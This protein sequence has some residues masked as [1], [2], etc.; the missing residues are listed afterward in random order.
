MISESERENLILCYFSMLKELY[1]WNFNTYDV[2]IHDGTSNEGV[3]EMHNKILETIVL[4]DDSNIPSIINELLAKNFL[5]NQSG[6]YS[7]TGK[8]HWND[9]IEIPEELK[10][11]YKQFSAKLIYLLDLGIS[12]MLKFNISLIL[13]N[14]ISCGV[15][16]ENLKR[17]YPKEVNKLL[18]LG[19]T[20]GEKIVGFHES[21]F[22]Y[23]KFN[24][25]LKSEVVKSLV[26]NE[27][28]TL[29]SKCKDFEKVVISV[30]AREKVI[31]RKGIDY[32]SVQERTLNKWEEKLSE[33]VV[34]IDDKVSE[35]SKNTK[36]KPTQITQIIQHLKLKGCL[37]EYKNYTYNVVHE[38]VLGVIPYPPDNF[39]IG[40]VKD[41]E[42]DSIPKADLEEKFDDIESQ[43][44]Q[45]KRKELGLDFIM[46]IK[47]YINDFCITTKFSEH[48]TP[49]KVETLLS[50]LEKDLAKFGWSETEEILKIFEN[51][52]ELIIE[53]EKT[54]NSKWRKLGKFFIEGLRSLPFIP[55]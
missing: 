24:E 9:I 51:E 22:L 4:K 52:F 49:K 31:I 42:I 37:W 39:I 33:I 40:K 13:L 34:N 10:E 48:P 17:L 6:R 27:K 1:D 36:L 54:N 35:C 46:T 50:L 44:R 41:F 43:Q 26:K 45:E 28:L 5:I 25:Y 16:E 11:D 18:A 3:K 55:K 14:L 20:N 23:Y 47:R 8:T 2:V 19:L 12:E 53:A 21:H 7:S 38:V 15:P 32:Y 29:F 30:L